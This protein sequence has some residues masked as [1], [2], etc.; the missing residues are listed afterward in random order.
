MQAAHD[1]GVGFNNYSY[2]DCKLV[3]HSSDTTSVLMCNAVCIVLL[4]YFY[5]LVCDLQNRLIEAPFLYELN[6]KIMLK[7]LVTSLQKCGQCDTLCHLDIPAENE[8][9]AFVYD[10]LNNS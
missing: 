5:P 7:P 3:N 4:S 2:F 9:V 6:I 10:V 1:V 8:Y